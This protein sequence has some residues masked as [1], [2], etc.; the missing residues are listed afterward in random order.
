MDKPLVWTI[1]VLMVSFA[2]CSMWLGLENP[3]DVLG[4]L[5]LAS[6]VVVGVAWYR[7]ALA[8][9]RWRSAW[10]AYARRD[11]AFNASDKQPTS[12]AARDGQGGLVAPMGHQESSRFRNTEGYAYAGAQS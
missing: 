5:A 8:Q 12:F 7:R 1:V 9:R 3:A 4:A 6:V 11:L 2:G 10:E